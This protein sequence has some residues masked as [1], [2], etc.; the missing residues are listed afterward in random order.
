LLAIAAPLLAVPGTQP[1]GAA[2]LGAGFALKA[3]A[4][5]LNS[6]GSGKSVS[7]SSGGGYSPNNSFAGFTPA[8]GGDSSLTTRLIGTD[9]LLSV[10]KSNKRMERVR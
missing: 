4:G 8:G 1:L 10:E 9:L 5:Y 6:Q 3:V 2:Y 7:G